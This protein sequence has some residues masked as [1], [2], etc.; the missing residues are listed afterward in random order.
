MEYI[1]NY[2][3][4]NICKRVYVY[5]GDRIS[6]LQRITSFV[7]LFQV[8]LFT[9]TAGPFE[10]LKKKTTRKRKL[11]DFFCV[12][13]FFFFPQLVSFLVERFSIFIWKSLEPLTTRRNGRDWKDCLVKRGRDKNKNNSR[14]IETTDRFTLLKKRD[15]YNIVWVFTWTKCMWMYMDVHMCI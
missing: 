8:P 4:I 12:F 14:Y 3:P 6:S 7:C 13:Y 10:K 1:W 5:I 11:L 15:V 2:T 9:S